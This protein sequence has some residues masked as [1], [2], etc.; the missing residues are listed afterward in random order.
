MRFIVLLKIFFQFYFLLKFLFRFPLR[1]SIFFQRGGKVVFVKSSPQQKN[2]K[3][4]VIQSL[5]QTPVPCFYRSLPVVQNSLCGCSLVFLAWL[6]CFLSRG[7]FVHP[8]P[9]KVASRIVC[10]VSTAPC[11]RLAC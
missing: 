10:W 6:I 5:S 11:V 3:T 4:R 8:D 1:V 2:I 9:F 7:Y